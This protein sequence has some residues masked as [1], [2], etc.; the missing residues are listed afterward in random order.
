[1]SYPH[2]P[3]PRPASSAQPLP[4]E[5]ALTQ[6]RELAPPELD[7]LVTRWLT[8]IG[9][10]D[11]RVRP[12]HGGAATYQAILGHPPLATPVH[13][14][15]YQRQNRLQAHHVD[16]FRGYLQ[17]SGIPGG[18]L[19]TTGGCSREASL[20]ARTAQGPLVC[21]LTGEQWAALLAERRTGLRPA[22]LLRWIVDLRRTLR[23][24]G[25]PAPKSTPER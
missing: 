24:W 1:M 9:L 14:R 20:I 12:H 17:R 3:T 21:L 7:T 18:L 4:W 11:A 6:L 5:P 2:F 8:Q 16:A 19:I 25:R 10:T 23:S 13:V 22:R 15:V